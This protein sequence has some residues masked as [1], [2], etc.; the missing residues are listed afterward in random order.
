MVW[1]DDSFDDADL[2]EAPMNEVHRLEIDLR[3]DC[4]ENRGLFL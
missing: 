1:S 4:K 3:M 2:E